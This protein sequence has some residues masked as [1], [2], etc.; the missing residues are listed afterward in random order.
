MSDNAE[1]RRVAV[2]MAANTVDVAVNHLAIGDE[3]FRREIIETL[4]A[5][6]LCCSV[7]VLRRA[8]Q[9]LQ[10]EGEGL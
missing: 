8:V 9:Q 5:K 10:E 7:E 1:A 6:W 4:Q 2:N 3:E